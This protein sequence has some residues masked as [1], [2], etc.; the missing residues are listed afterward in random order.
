MPSV[1][2]GTW[3][4]RSPFQAF[5]HTS[6]MGSRV[7][8][9]DVTHLCIVH[10]DADARDGLAGHVVDAADGVCELLILDRE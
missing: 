6:M 1:G 10:A 7:V 2:D 8:R 4:S 5:Q 3:Y 9:E